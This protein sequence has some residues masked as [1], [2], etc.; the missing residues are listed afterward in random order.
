MGFDLSLPMQGISPYQWHAHEMIYG[1]SV[2]VVAGFLLTAIKNWTNVQTLQ[3][4]SLFILFSLWAAARLCWMFGT[5]LILLAAVFDIA[6]NIFLF[7]GT[8]E[9]VARVKQWNQMGIVSKV[10]LLSITNLLFYLGV[11]GHL[12]QGVEWGLLGGVLL[13]LA[14]I[15]TMGRRVMPSFIQNGVGYSVQLKNSILLDRSSLVLFLLFA[16]TA[17]F[18]QQPQITSLFAGCL[19]VVNLIRLKNWH[20]SG[21]WKFSLLWGLYGAFIFLIIGFFIYALLPYSTHVTRSIAVHTF[22]FGVIALITVSMMS[23]VTLGHTG[24]NILQPSALIG[25][26]QGLI[27]LGTIIRIVPTSFAFELYNTWILISQLL[28]IMAFALFVWVNLPHLIKPRID[29]APG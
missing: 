1:Y 25:Y 8:L 5:E 14:L 7:Y 21:I 27:V 3:Y 29:G 11:L 23:R 9:P 17:L 24:R 28:W 13:L 26:A 19:V 16:I 18:L 6:F 15:M 2:A 12:E 22:T 20:T 4:R 10:L